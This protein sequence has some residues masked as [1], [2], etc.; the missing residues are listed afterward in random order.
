[1]NPLEAAKR[2]PPV[3]WLIGI[4][5]VVGLV[6]LKGTGGGG[7][8]VVSGGT[9]GGGSTAGVDELE[10]LAQGYVDLVAEME[11]LQAENEAWRTGIEEELDKGRELWPPDRPPVS[12]PVGG[13]VTRP[14]SRWGPEWAK[15]PR[16]FSITSMEEVLRR[17]GVKSWGEVINKGD[18]AK[19][20]KKEGINYGSTINISDIMKL[21]KK[22]GVKPVGPTADKP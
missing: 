18:V 9:G 13:G 20:L 17:S 22:T 6:I 21:Y 4:A 7:G 8:G 16:V 5:V 11:A 1:M 14:R 3:A 12:P 10:V 2:I 15:A 19:A